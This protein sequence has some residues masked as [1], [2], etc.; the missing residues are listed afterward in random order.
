MAGFLIGE[1]AENAR[2]EA[3]RL[4]VHFANTGESAKAQMWRRV[5]NAVANHQRAQK[6]SHP[7]DKR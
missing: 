6:A 4:A 1:H 5:A 3:S 7:W 2:A